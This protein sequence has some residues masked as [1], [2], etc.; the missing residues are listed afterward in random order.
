M[1]LCVYCKKKFRFQCMFKIH[2]HWCR[3][4]DNYVV[5]EWD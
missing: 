2:Q 1:Y 5:Y 3:D 4:D